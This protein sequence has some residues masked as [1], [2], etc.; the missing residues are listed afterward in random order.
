[1]YARAIEESEARLHELRLEERGGFGLAALFLGSCLAGSFVQSA[2]T[3]PFLFGGLSGCVLGMRA[4]L[5][6]WN[7]LDQIAG[8]CDAYLIAEVREWA[9]RDATPERRRDLAV[10]LR[11]LLARHGS[12]SNERLAGATAE[13]EALAVD[14]DDDELLLDPAAAVAC[15]RLLTDPVNSPL[16]DAAG[17]PEDVR[18]RV[19]QIRSGFHRSRA[20]A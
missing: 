17:R 20:A 8:E 7:L 11:L 4:A 1:M 5:R 10:S 16:F 6:R 18:S 19:V 12:C 15:A 13:L 14:L 3:L 2:L 9:L